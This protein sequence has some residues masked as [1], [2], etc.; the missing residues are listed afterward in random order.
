MTAR[1]VA[2][3]FG[4]IAAALGVIQAWPQARRVRALGHSQGVSQV[5]WMM[6]A[7]SSACWLGFGLRESSPSLVAST[8]ASGFM[9]MNV[10]VAINGR[11]RHVIPRMVPLLAAALFGVWFLPAVVTTPVLFAFTLS[12]VPQMIRSWRS[13]KSGIAETAVSPGW[14]ALGFACLVS[15][16]VYSVLLRD[17]VL[18]GTTTAAMVSN[19]VVAWLELTNPARRTPGAATLT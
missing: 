11:P 18:I 1:S 8:V 10:V 17:A 9:N 5:M 19:M 12:R 4:F 14:L 6:M 3:L 2:E 16:E 13:R 7:V 15:W